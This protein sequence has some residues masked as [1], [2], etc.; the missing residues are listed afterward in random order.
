M[1]EKI[2]AFKAAVAAVLGALASFLGWKGI[3]A[4]V[5]VALMA[6]DYASGSWAACVE[7]NWNSKTARSGLAHKGGMVLVV[8][9]AA[10]ADWALIAASENLALGFVWPGIVFPLVLTWYIITEI[11]SILENA[12]RMGAPVPKWLINLM[13]VSLKAVEKLGDIS[14]SDDAP[15]LPAEEQE[16]KNE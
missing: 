14:A 13:T 7:G 1:E 5:W 10:L 6:A 4:V 15:P 16:E 3:L 2:T 8:L 9:V 12:A 11:G